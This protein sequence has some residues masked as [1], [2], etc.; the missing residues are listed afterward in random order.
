MLLGFE[1]LWFLGQLEGFVPQSE[2]WFSC[3]QA[4]W[5][6]TLGI[7]LLNACRGNSAVVGG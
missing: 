4:F 5:A 1:R 2:R 6:R 3:F 7:K